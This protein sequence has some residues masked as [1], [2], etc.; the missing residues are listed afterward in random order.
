MHGLRGLR[1]LM[2]RPMAPS[3]WRQAGV[4]IVLVLTTTNARAD[5]PI[6]I[7]LTYEAPAECPTREAL[8]SELRARV[9]PSWLLGGD[10]RRFDARI[11][12]AENGQFAGSLAIEEPNRAPRVR[13]VEAKTCRAAV[14]S[15]AVFLSI[16]L[17][18]ETQEAPLPIEAPAPIPPAPMIARP[19]P[20]KTPK[21]PTRAPPAPLWKWNAGVNATYLHMPEGAWGSRVH[22]ELARGVLALRLSWGFSSFSTFPDRAGEAKFALK[23]TR[24]EGCVRQTMQRI[25]VSGCGGLDV[26]T[27]SG[28]DQDLRAAVSQTVQWTSAIAVLRPTL[29][30]LP[31][32]FVSAEASLVVP[33]ERT[34]F[35]LSDP[36]RFVYRAPPV[37]FGGGAGLEV[38]ARFP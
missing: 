34:R 11:V 16:A 24:L 28:H 3:C 22:G 32:L 35:A 38:T 26:G 14:T 13:V 7:A 29:S 1:P 37:L 36:E 19:T 6:G 20:K 33:F 27:L 23:T 15:I 8:E 10:A 4:A 17:D 25:S 5:G 31:W 9:D 21:P 30:I 18:P 2:S 12:R